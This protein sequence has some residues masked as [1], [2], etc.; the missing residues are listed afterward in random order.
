[1]LIFQ[2]ADIRFAL[3]KWKI[4]GKMSIEP[5]NQFVALETKEN[6]YVDN[7][8]YAI[9]YPAP[10]VDKP[11]PMQKKYLATILTKGL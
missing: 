11:N 8:E 4:G 3:V 7:V 2:K 5:M 1:M 10:S 6:D 9:Y